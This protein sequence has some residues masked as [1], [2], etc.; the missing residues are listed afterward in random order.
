[1]TIRPSQL[2]SRCEALH[3]QEG[4]HDDHDRRQDAQ[5]EEADADVPLEPEA[6]AEAG[7]RVRGQRAE[8]ERDQDADRRD[9][10][11]VREVRAEVAA[12]EEAAVVRERGRVRVERAVLRDLAVGLERRLD[13]PHERCERDDRRHDEREVPQALHAGAT[14]RRMSRTARNAQAR[15]IRATISSIAAA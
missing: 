8:H 14:P 5:R 2:L 4:G 3:D 1:M 12:G 11:R 10:D 6:Q 9:A 7:E 15:T 13:H